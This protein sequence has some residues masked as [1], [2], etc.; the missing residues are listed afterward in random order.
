MTMKKEDRY[1]GRLAARSLLSLVAM[2]IIFS[3]I[4][5]FIGY[6]GITDSLLDHYSGEAFQTAHDA[7]ELIDADEIDRMMAEGPD[8][9]EY[10]ELHSK[11]ESMT[12][13]ARVTFIYVIQ[14]DL[15]DYGHIT[16]FI[17]TV[18]RHSGFEPFDFGFVRETTNDEY[19]VKY[20]NLYKGTTKE[21]LVLRVKGFIDTDPHITAMIPLTGK[22][23]STKAILCVQRQMEDL[24]SVR[25]KYIE[26][27]FVLMALF[28]LLMMLTQG[29]YVNNMLIEP[30]GRISAEARRFAEYN[31][32]S[33]VRLTD[34]VKNRDEIGDLAASIDGME[35]QIEEYI[36]NLTAF[37]AEK[38]RISTELAL[39]SR[40]QES[41]LP[42]AFPA[43]PEREEFDIYAMMSA[44][45]EVGGDFYDFFMI[46]DDHLGI[47][48]ADVSGKGV[49]AAIFM[50][51][52]MIRIRS[53]AL[54]GAGPAEA[55]RK[56]N[57]DICANNEQEMFVTVWLGILE[58]S[59]GKLTAANAGHEYPVIKTADG[60]FKLYKDPHGFV[61]GGMEDVTYREYEIKLERGSCVF[62]YTDGL[63]EAQNA[64]GQ[65]F[66]TERLEEVLNRHR[67]EDPETLLRTVSNAV[68]EFTEGADQF[69]DLTM[70]CL[71]YN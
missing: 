53:Q 49:P 35:A 6:K 33:E 5:G 65:F 10:R 67:E 25:G 58:I 14:P 28:A 60:G 63:P 43:F 34:I 17:S 71:R 18:S 19:K 39:A 45:K 52:S 47:V 9:E 27:F 4:M 21:E 61:I 8:T 70:L 26:R 57:N 20:D 50:T 11:I 29:L 46:D 42:N 41:M 48:M 30:L 1:K 56:A 51:A 32:R 36:R 38:E 16:F 54:T 68:G 59:S 55:L 31:T 22:D 13:S 69:D 2:L 15:T 66:G 3:G 40:I 23:G 24:Y 44:A 64:D 37:T 12:N 7:A 62:V